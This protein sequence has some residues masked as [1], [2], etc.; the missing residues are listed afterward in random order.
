M[1]ATG[2]AKAF[3]LAAGLGTRLRPLTDATPKCLIPIGGRPLLHWWLEVCARLGVREVLLNTHHL[4]EQVRAFV[5]A[6]VGGPRIVLFHEDALLGSAGTLVANKSFVAGERDFW[7][8]Y[9]DTLIGGDLAGLSVLH[10]A[11]G[12]DLTLGLFRSPNPSSGGVVELADDGRVL[13]FEEKPPAPKS[14]MVAAGAYVAGPALLDVLP[15]GPGDLSRDVYPKLMS[16]AY[17]AVLEPV[18]DLGTPESYARAREEWPRFGLE[19]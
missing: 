7:I 16:K 17:G 6:R 13:S 14:D 15:P 19:R 11:R 4:A 18:I 5:R 10:R 3:L 2:P 9:A 1:S 8:F 12:A